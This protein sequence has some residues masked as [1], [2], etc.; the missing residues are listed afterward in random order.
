MASIRAKRARVRAMA[1]TRVK[2][3]ESEQ[4]PEPEPKEPGS[5]PQLQHYIARD[6][7]IS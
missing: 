1:S 4:Q 7:Y 3:P 6:G 2:E 5:E